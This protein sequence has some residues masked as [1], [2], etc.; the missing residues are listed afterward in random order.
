MIIALNSTYK[1]R[2]SI[3]LMS[4]KFK[5]KAEMGR[6]FIGNCLPIYIAHRYYCLTHNRIKSCIH[7]SF[8]ENH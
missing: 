1:H 2:E 6:R 5:M 7:K 4:K 3:I 8:L